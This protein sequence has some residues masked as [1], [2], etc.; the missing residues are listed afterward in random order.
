VNQGR[1]GDKDLRVKVSLEKNIGEV[2][3]DPERFEQVVRN[4]VSNAIEASPPGEVVIVQTGFFIPSEKASEAGGLESESYFE[5][6]IGNQGRRIPPDELQKIFSPFYTTKDYG[7]GIGL[8]LAKKI[9]E[10]HR[11]SISVKSDEDGTIFTLWLPLHQEE[12]AELVAFSLLV[13]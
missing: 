10:D 12:P 5:M 8:T 11:G 4:L 6:K 1:F 13:S 3:L 9:V 7:T 2:P